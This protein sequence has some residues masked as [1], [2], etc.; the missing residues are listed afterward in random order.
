MMTKTR[1]LNKGAMKVHLVHQR[2]SRTA[3]AAHAALPAA[4]GRTRA[5]PA[6]DGKKRKH[7]CGRAR[8]RKPAAPHAAGATAARIGSETAATAIGRDIRMHIIEQGDEAPRAYS[9]L[10]SVRETLE[11]LPPLIVP[12]QNSSPPS[13]PSSPP[14]RARAAPQQPWARPRSC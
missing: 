1:Q 7:T 10:S 11:R 2:N 13:P 14:P 9:T 6:C 4:K 3:T 8:K 5:C 12:L